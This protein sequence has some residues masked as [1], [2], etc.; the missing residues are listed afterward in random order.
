MRKLILS[1]LT[2]HILSASKTFYG[3]IARILNI[4]I[5]RFS[6]DG[7]GIRSFTL[8]ELLIVIAI[9]AVLAAAVVVVINP[10]EMLSQSKDAERVVDLKNISK[11]ITSV[12]AE[13]PS[14]AMGSANTVYIS[15]PDTSSTCATNIANLPSLPTGWA[16]HCSTTTDYRKVDGTGW[17]PIDFRNSAGGGL[18]TLPIDPVNI[19]TPGRQY[20]AYATN[21]DKQFEIGA[22]MESQKYILNAQ[23]DGGDQLARVE[24]GSFLTIFPWVQAFTFDNGYFPITGAN[25]QFGW[26]KISGSGTIAAIGDLMRATGYV[27]YDWQ[28]NIAFDP[29]ATYKVSCGVNQITEPTTGG[30]SIY[31]GFVGIAANGTT[32]V[33]RSG[34]TSSTSQYFHAANATSQVAGGGLVDYTGYT[35]G[36]GS[37]GTAGPCPLI[38]SPC[39]VHNNV[40]FVRPTFWLNYS[41]GNGIADIDYITIVKE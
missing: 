11:A 27:R 18:A 14:A 25:P 38:T 21:V 17:L 1:I 12:Q 37:T 6:R 24:M 10:G 26:K 33:S 23:K 29:L 7:K 15:I 32:F 4:G 35:K 2:D 28:Q 5:P 30:K 8:V 19:P 22:A 13:N 20:Y 36:K 40:S 39:I 9:L 41:S 34:S 3:I 16:Y 31:C